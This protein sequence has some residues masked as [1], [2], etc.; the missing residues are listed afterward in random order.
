[1]EITLKPTSSP[2]RASSPS[3]TAAHPRRTLR[4]RPLLLIPV[5]VILIV[6]M[7]YVVTDGQKQLE[8]AYFV[9][10]MDNLTVAYDQV[11]TGYQRSAQII[12]N[13]IVNQPEVLS[14]VAQANG[15]AEEEQSESR[16]A[17]YDLLIEQYRRLETLNLRQLHFHLPDN[18]SFLRFHSPE[19]FGD[20]LTNV[21]FTI[22][23]ANSDLVPVV[24]FEEGRIFNGFR[25]VFPL[26][27]DEQHVGSVETSVSF[28]AVQAD[29]NESLPGASNFMIRS[30]VVQA[31]VFQDQQS[32][33][34]VSDITEAYAYDRPVLEAFTDEDLSWETIQSINAALDEAVVTRL[35]AGETFSTALTVD[36]VGY[37]ATFMGVDN[38]LGEHVAYVLAYKA[39]SLIPSSR[40][41]LVVT[42]ASIIAA[43]LVIV[44]ALV[45]L[46]RSTI[47]INRQRDQLAA[48]NTRLEQT[49]TA[50]DAARHQAEAAN[51]LKSQFLANMS[52]EL[53]TPLNAILN[54]TRFVSE[55]MMGE[56]NE[57]QVET[58]GKVGDNG[59][60][61]LSLI[62]DLLDIS[63][64]EAGQLKLFVEDDVNLSKE[65]NTAADVAQSL[66][67]DKPVELV[68]EIDADLPLIVS[69]RRR[70][71]Q[72][73]LNLVSNACKFTQAGKVTVSLRRSGD[74]LIFSVS[75]TGPGIAPEDHELI[76]ETFRQAE[77]GLKHGG[78]GLGLPI[79]RRLA[80]ILGGRLDMESA[81][82][83]GAVF[84]LHLPIASDALVLMKHDQDSLVPA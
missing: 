76:F 36:G 21:R 19:N 18:T 52:H 26:F 61:L 82:G 58:L 83:K 79:S 34:V 24:G 81:P 25:Y 50:L 40:A 32:N 66:L 37:T 7:L 56:V 8:A 62:N 70:I 63:K 5:F 49:N 84:T 47:F 29:L 65:F 54:F 39:D 9:G 30:D 60:H 35:E 31:T 75:D 22:M 6:V 74:E 80:V 28:S 20:N 59:K 57:V 17:L 46:D 1:M 10:E 64:I 48:Q 4:L 68:K 51:Q 42:Q 55:G 38:F 77:Q 43:G 69:D 13:E 15:A 53:R 44:L 41:G 72:I 67:A 78:S 12:Y 45:Y 33:Y 3:S 2:Q 11:I 71:R 23:K 27:Y 14:L 73:M 16:A